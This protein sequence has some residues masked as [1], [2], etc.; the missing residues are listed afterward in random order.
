MSSFP[1]QEL[2]AELARFPADAEVRWVQEEPENHGAWLFVG[3]HVQRLANRPVEHIS[4]SQASAPAVASARR[5]T[6]EQK[7]LVAS[8][9]H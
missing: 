8:A 1:E 2:N 7:Q 6:G 9:F 5:H 4:R 3:P